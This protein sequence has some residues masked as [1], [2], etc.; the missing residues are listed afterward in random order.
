MSLMY[1][2]FFECVAI[3][4][5]YGTKRLSANIKDMSGNYPNAFCQLCWK[6][7]SPLLIMVRSS[8]ISFKKTI[9]LKKK[10]KTAIY[11]LI[12]L[13]SGNLDFQHTRL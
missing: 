10:E 9:F 8:K 7:I 6:Y 2:A 11:V 13:F 12:I 1:I 3:V 5:I 4:W